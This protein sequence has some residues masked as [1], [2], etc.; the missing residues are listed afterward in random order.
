MRF[1]FSGK[2]F[3]EKN[4][5]IVAS[6]LRQLAGLASALGGFYSLRMQDGVATEAR[7]MARPNDRQKAVKNGLIIV[8][9]L[10]ALP[11]AWRW[12]P[13]QEVVNFETVI[14][15]QQAARSSPATFFLVLA[16]YLAATLFL[17]PVMILNVATVLTF[18][19]FL[20]NAYALA[21]WVLSATIGYGIGRF[22]GSDLLHRMAGPRLD[23]LVRQL[24]DHGFATVLT[25]RLVP[26]APFTLGNLFVGASGIGYRDFFWASLLGRIPGIVILSMAGVHL[27][28]ALRDPSVGRLLLGALALALIP[29]ATVCVSKRLASARKRGGN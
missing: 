3:K 13:L 23:P 7:S 5:R 20:G 26:M 29:L 25:I 18:G 15:F 11:A 24:G 8:F 4:G 1:E 6:A 9:L 16:I 12:T 28:S 2:F 10:L 19:P 27:E 14:N 17:F 21:G 22:L